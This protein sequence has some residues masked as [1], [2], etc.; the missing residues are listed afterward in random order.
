MALSKPQRIALLLVLTAIIGV[1]LFT[2]STRAV[3]PGMA[4]RIAFSPAPDRPRPILIDVE[5]AVG[6]PGLYWVGEGTRVQEAVARAGGLRGDAELSAINLAAVVHDGE[7]LFVPFAG[8][9]PGVQP[10]GVRSDN[11][12]PLAARPVY[13][14]ASAHRTRGSTEV[15][16]LLAGSI[17]VN[18]APAEELARLPKLGLSRA[19]RIVEYRSIHGPFHSDQDLDAVPGIGPGTLR[20][21]RP[22][23]AY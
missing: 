22:Y 20:I 2:L 1:S 21:I 17:N 6:Y 19:Q 4:D 16:P 8:R 5:G 11:V 15:K 18:T 12:Q 14:S 7:R 13:P 10:S 9:P 3:V 23:L